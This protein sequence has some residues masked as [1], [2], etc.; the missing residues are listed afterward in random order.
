MG[1]RRWTLRHKVDDVMGEYQRARD[2][3][4]ASRMYN[5]RAS[6]RRCSRRRRKCSILFSLRFPIFSPPWT[7]LP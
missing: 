4:C 3:A 5:S 1:N 6:W 2:T 7:A